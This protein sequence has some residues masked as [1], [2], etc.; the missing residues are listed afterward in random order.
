MV[1]CVLIVMASMG[2]IMVLGPAQRAMAQ[3][4][5]PPAPGAAPQA[6]PQAAAPA[7]PAT[8]HGYCPPQSYTNYI[9]YWCPQYYWVPQYYRVDIYNVYR[10]HDYW[11]PQYYCV[12]QYHYHNVGDYPPSCPSGA[13]YCGTAAPAGAPAPAAPAPQK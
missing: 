10:R 4:A 9:D 2:A 3:D 8:G 13:P 1:R 6:A 12:P 5:A 7:A 11:V